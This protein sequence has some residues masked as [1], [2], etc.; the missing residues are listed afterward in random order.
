MRIAMVASEV[1]PFS[2]TGGLGDVVGALPGALES[3]GADVLT[4]SPL[5]QCVRRHKPKRTDVRLRVPLGTGVID[6]PVWRKG[7]AWF[8]EHD[9]FFD[10][11]GLYTG[12]WGDHGDNAARFT[13]LA[14]GAMELLRAVGLPDVLHAHDWQAG[15]VPVYARTLYAGDFGRV[16]TVFSIHNLAYQ[17][18]FRAVDLPMTG[19][20]WSLY[21]WKQLE[22]Y[23]KLSFMKAGLVF[24]DLLTTVS[25]TYAREIQTPEHGYGLDGV[26]R[27]RAGSLRGILNGADYAEWDPRSDRHLAERYSPEDLKGKAACKAD[28]QRSCGFDPRPDVP[29]IALVSRLAEQKGVE[30]VLGGLERVLG[31]DVQVALLG[32][33][34]GRFEEAFKGWAARRPDRF[35]ARIA[36]DNAVAHRLEAGADLFLMPSRYEPCGL[37]QLYSLRYGTV[38]VV[39]ATG[40]LADTV[41]DGATGFS[42]GPSTVDA[43]LDAL[44]RALGVYR[45]PDEWRRIQA[46]GMSEDFGWPASA[47]EY[48]RLYAAR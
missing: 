27:D 24:A 38:P 2:K 42:F 35:S 23:G 22:F 29:V 39:R 20:D 7:N 3:L 10:R 18:N 43:M 33:G 46:A 19:L 32:N 6:T 4:I 34:E 40:G 30:L 15:L 36:F 44:R 17:G 25:P 8:L 14:R 12:P 41:R 28:L 9:P 5:H 26:L 11:E 31:E 37:N 48:L 21:N 16:K 45:D 1:H 13:F 47:R